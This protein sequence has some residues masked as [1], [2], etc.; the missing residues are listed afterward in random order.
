MMV[1]YDSRVTPDLKIPH[2]MTLELKF[3]IIEPYKIDHWTQV[4]VNALP[5]A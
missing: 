4:I 5:K 1:N 3:M 2:I